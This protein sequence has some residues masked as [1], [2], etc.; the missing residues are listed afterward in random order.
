MANSNNSDRF[1]SLTDQDI[2]NLIS[3]KNSKNTKLGTSYSIKI[4]ED[5][6]VSKLGYS[7]SGN[8]ISTLA[9]GPL[10]EIL[11]KFYAEIRTKDGGFYSKN[12]MIAIRF[13]INR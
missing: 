13:G 3:N 4:L 9:A 2:E 6:C 11:K 5:Y 10:A 1:A 8:A 7:D 12:S